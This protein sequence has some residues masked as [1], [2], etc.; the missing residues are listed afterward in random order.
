MI[1]RYFGALMTDICNY[2]QP[3]PPTELKSCLHIENERHLDDALLL[4]LGVPCP[5]NWYGCCND[6]RH[7]DMGRRSV[8]IRNRTIY[9]FIIDHRE[10]FT[11]NELLPD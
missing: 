9:G 5:L 4:P 6:I 8:Y 2:V 10:F 3:L 11:A 1:K 7:G